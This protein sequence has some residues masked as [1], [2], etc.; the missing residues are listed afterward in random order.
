MR[1]VT[2]IIVALIV[3][4]IEV[5]L[6]ASPAHAASDKV[7]LTGVSDVSFGLI[8]GTADQTIS[9]SVCA[10]SSSN[11]NRYSVMAMGDGSGGS[12][13]LSSGAARL[14][15]DVLWADVGNQTSGTALVPGAAIG[16]FVSLAS[17]QTCN[18]GPSSS[19]SLIVIIRSAAL[20]AAIAG[21]Y[22]GALQITIAPE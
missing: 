21:S 2:Y 11:T 20:S 3:G 19:A 6:A 10:Y 5:G 7:R 12:F 22:V 15:Y 8:A 16:G 14:S 13:E 18:S 4:A 9:Q 1:S 17:Q